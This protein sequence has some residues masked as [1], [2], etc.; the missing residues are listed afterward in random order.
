MTLNVILVSTVTVGVA[1]LVYKTF[2]LDR[3]ATLANKLAM[4][5]LANVPNR[6]RRPKRWTEM[7]EHKATV[8]IMRAF[9]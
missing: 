4:Y 3:W 6:L 7:D 8:P 2:Y 9:D 5:E 1:I